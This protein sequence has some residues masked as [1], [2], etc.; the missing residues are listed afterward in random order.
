MC[1]TKLITI[2]SLFLCV[3]PFPTG[4]QL[5]D[6]P[7]ASAVTTQTKL[8]AAQQEKDKGSPKSTDPAERALDVVAYAAAMIPSFPKP[9]SQVPAYATLAETLWPYDP[10]RARDFFRAA[11]AALAKIDFTLKPKDRQEARA[12]EQLKWW[13]K[14]ART[15]LLSRIA[16]LDL[17]LAKELAKMVGEDEVKGSSEEGALT[18]ENIGLTYQRA[19]ELV[20]TDPEQAA[21]L[22]RQT[23]AGGISPMLLEFLP[24]LRRR[25]PA[26][27]D[28]LFDQALSV[29]LAQS[30]PPDPAQLHL[31]GSY[32]LQARGQVDP[33]LSRRFLTIMA[34]A[35]QAQ[36]EISAPLRRLSPNEQRFL[37]QLYL[38]LIEQY[39]PDL[40]PGMQSLLTYLTAS[41]PGGTAQNTQPG[42]RG[43]EPRLS[44]GEVGGASGLLSPD[45]ESGGA[46]AAEGVILK[47]S[48]EKLRQTLLDARR[49]NLARQAL[50][51]N[52]IEEASQIAQQIKD[53]LKQIDLF[54]ELGKR[55]ADKDTARAAM[56][57]DNAYQLIS[58][59]DDLR[60]RATQAFILAH[61]TLELN[62]DR[63]F[64]YAQGAVTALN[65]RRE[66]ESA[67]ADPGMDLTQR[68]AI[69]AQL[70][71]IFVPLGR[72]DFEQAIYLA[73]QLQDPEQR[74]AAEVAACRA[75]LQS[76]KKKNSDSTQNQP[77]VKEYK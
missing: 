1:T 53:T 39:T 38:P 17:D 65:R 40:A 23:L 13:K 58:R 15:Q 22:A 6:T 56:F 57:F 71:S 62:R 35:L 7:T 29:I 20:E 60:E 14:S 47:L 67:K 70:E 36:A 30:N 26:L 54:A 11:F 49:Y 9:E 3:A 27:A 51:E 5:I 55:L 42:G 68:E 10:A 64:Q 76:A 41:T 66:T 34:Y 44:R 69:R 18:A 2:V 28:Q 37:V 63:A 46:S 31:L 12:Q 19:F 4:V 32:L 21:A 74:V 50:E 25:A 33:G 77:A 72:A 16:Q 8:E 59:L 48:D 52:K 45:Q 24:A 43:Q 75:V 73:I 61:F